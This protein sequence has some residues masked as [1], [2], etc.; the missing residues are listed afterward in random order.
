MSQLY[1]VRE[2]TGFS[3][4]LLAAA[5]LDDDKAKAV[6]EILVEG[7][8][9]GHTT[10]GLQLL[11]PYLGEIQS[12]RMPVTGGQEVIS[13][14]AAVEA[15]DGRYLPGPWLIIQAMET[16]E[17][18]ARSCGTGTVVIRRSNHI[19]CLAAYLKRATDRDLVVVIESSDPATKSV[20]PYGGLE[21]THTPNPIAVGYPTDSGPVLLDVST[22]ITTNGMVGRLNKQNSRLPYP[23]L[24]DHQGRATDRPSVLFDEPKGSIMPIGGLDHGH[25][26]YAL[27]LM[28][29][30]LTSGLAGFGRVQAPTQWGASVMVQ[31]MDPEAFGGLEAFKRET[32]ALVDACR[33]NPVPEGSPPVRIPG[34]RGLALHQTYSQQ[35]VPLP[36]GVPEALSD[37]SE[38][39]GVPFP[40]AL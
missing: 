11:S 31:V 24:K 8:L 7:D 3:T 32:G 20:A 33:T 6:A 12:G 21:A 34:E 14:R 9:M 17:A 30:A 4:R 26:G 28:V 10:H 38:R 37:W 25:K 16:A 15:W 36:E 22:S 35:G 19:A 2:M 39:L 5:G 23:W 1:D 27:G 18:M 40:P 13:K 29:E